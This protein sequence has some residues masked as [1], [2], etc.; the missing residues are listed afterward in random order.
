[1]SWLFK[2]PLIT[3]LFFSHILSTSSWGSLPFMQI[4]L[5]HTYISLPL[6]EAG[7]MY[8]PLGFYTSLSYSYFLP[9]NLSVFLFPI[10]KHLRTIC[11]QCKIFT[12]RNTFSSKHLALFIMKYSYCEFL[13]TKA[14]CSSSL[15]SNLKLLIHAD[16]LGFP[17]FQFAICIFKYRLSAFLLVIL[18]PQ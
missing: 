13:H 12:M 10:Q 18:Y 4:I 11:G 15:Y 8:F 14:E 17:Y 9:T 16:S 7:T 1:M 6:Q 2:V 3:V 5:N